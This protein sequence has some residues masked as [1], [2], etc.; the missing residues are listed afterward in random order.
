MKGETPLI[1][2]HFQLQHPVVAP[3]S[4]IETKLNV[5]AQR[6]TFPYPMISKPLLSSNGF[7]A[8]SVLSNFAFNSVTERQA[9][10]Q[11]D[12]QADKISTLLASPAAFEVR[13]PLDLAW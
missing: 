6:Q 7:W 11:T 9:D 4:G 13:T 5:G 10:R 12:R 3:F 1:L 2:P 8:K